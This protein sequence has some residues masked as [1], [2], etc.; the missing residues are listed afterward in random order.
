VKQ[1]PGSLPKARAQS[2]IIGKTGKDLQASFG[3]RDTVCSNRRGGWE[4]HFQER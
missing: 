3:P 4:R 1:E 2:V